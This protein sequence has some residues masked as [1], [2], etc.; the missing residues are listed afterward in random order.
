MRLMQAT[1][2]HTEAQLSPGTLAGEVRGMQQKTRTKGVLVPLHGT[3]QAL[4][5]P[6][7]AVNVLGPCVDAQRDCAARHCLEGVL[8]D[9]QVAGHQREQVAGLHKGILPHC[10]VPASP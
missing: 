6:G 9:G 8:S 5:G 7:N 2:L 3:L 1:L 4:H 10:K